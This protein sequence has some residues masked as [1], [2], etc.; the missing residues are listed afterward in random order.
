MLTERSYSFTT[1]TE[2]EIVR[3]VKEKLCY[4]ASDF[5][6]EMKAATKHARLER[7]VGEAALLGDG[8]LVGVRPDAHVRLDTMI[9][10]APG[11]HEALRPHVVRELRAELLDDLQE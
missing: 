4:V 10:V 6:T 8:A 1:T 7:R 5:D 3:D 9:L 2:R 11:L